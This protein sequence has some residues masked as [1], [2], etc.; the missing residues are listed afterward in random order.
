MSKVTEPEER[1]PFV[2]V[3]GN[4]LKICDLVEILK[5]GIGPPKQFVKQFI[6]GLVI[7]PG[8]WESTIKYDGGRRTE[9]IENTRLRIK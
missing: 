6:Y 9:T 4:R 8:H 1:K 5:N 7:K 3:D 2:D